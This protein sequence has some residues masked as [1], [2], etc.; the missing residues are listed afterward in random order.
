MNTLLETIARRIRIA[1]YQIEQ[2]ARWRALS[3]ITRR[4]NA[5]DA[6]WQ[7][8]LAARAELVK[9]ANPAVWAA[10]AAQRRALDEAIYEAV[11][12]TYHSGEMAGIDPF[13]HQAVQ[14]G[15]QPV[16]ASAAP[17]IEKQVAA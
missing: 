4:D 13:R 17:A 7:D 10:I 6:A 1:Q 9:S 12:H 8:H 11:Q 5:H 15:G 3:R 2:Q 16:I 14:R